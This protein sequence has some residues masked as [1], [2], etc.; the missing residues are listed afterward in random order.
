MRKRFL[1]FA[2]Y[3]SILPA[4]AYGGQEPFP[5]RIGKNA[6]PDLEERHPHDRVGGPATPHWKNGMALPLIPRETPAEPGLRKQRDR[7]GI[8]GP[9]RER[10]RPPRR[11]RLRHWGPTTTT[12]VVKE[13]PTIVIVNPP[14]A[15]EPPPP[16]PR[17]TWVPPVMG[18]RTEPGYWD[19][20]V[21]K[22]WMGDHWRYEQDFTEKTWVPASQVKYVK[23]AGY[24]KV[25]E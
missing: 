20:G 11:G 25:A 10:N 4:I 9:D 23:Q 8:K 16:E 7:R 3:F 6:S 22:V 19:Y 12:T 21:K 14:P 24:W 2:I 1:I 13:S 15:E 18:I 17:K 5:S